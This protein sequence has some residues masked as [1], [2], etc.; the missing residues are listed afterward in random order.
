MD[1]QVFEGPEAFLAGALWVCVT[2]PHVRSGSEAGGEGKDPGYGW[3]QP[4]A[5][6]CCVAP[7][8]SQSWAQLVHAFSAGVISV[9][10]GQQL[11]LGGLNKF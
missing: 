7:R 8:Q 2:G 11:V 10:T 3:G 6:G 4:S 9:P 5:S 1:P